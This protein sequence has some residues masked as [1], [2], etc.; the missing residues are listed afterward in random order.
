MSKIKPFKG[1]RPKQELVEKV[2]APPYDVLDSDEARKM[3]EGNECSFLHVSKPE[4]DLEPGVDLYSN[5]VYEKAR[6]NFERFRSEYFE[7]EDSPVFYIYRLSYQGH[8]Q[9]GLVAGVSVAEYDKD[10]I[11]KHE[12]TR[13]AKEKDRTRHTATIGAHTGPV[14]LAY[15][16]REEIDKLVNQRQL[17]EPVYDVTTMDGVRN[18]IWVVPET[19]PLVKAFEQV[20]CTYIA[21]GHHRAASYARCGRERAEKDPN[22][23]GEES[24]NFFMAVLFPHDQLRILP[25]NRVVNGLNGLS[26]VEFLD[27]ITEKFAVTQDGMAAPSTRHRFCMYLDG[28][29]Y[30]IEPKEGSYD[31]ND[32]VKRL[33]VSILQENLLSPILGIE[34]PRRDDRIDFV[35]GIRGT[36]ELERRVQK[37]DKV[38]MSVAFSLYPVSM[39]E[40]FAISDAG[41]IM[42]PKSTWFEPKL[43]DGF[44]LRLIED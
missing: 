24:Y 2:V 22:T 4:I 13:E 23:T 6:E 32:P 42:P 10:L 40:L 44:V 8:L 9:S 21:D 18:E 31:E 38:R 20:P 34:D 30:S 41:E 27:R 29:W 28:E 11:K 43:K 1:L 25:Y 14:F 7:R 5:A 12:L 37:W 16:K 15:R 35:G 36:S 33:D 39:D 19:D 17:T 3:A 26:K